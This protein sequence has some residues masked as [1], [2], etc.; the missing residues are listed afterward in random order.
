MSSKILSGGTNYNN[1]Y[2]C[3]VIVCMCQMLDSVFFFYVNTIHTSFKSKGLDNGQQTDFNCY[4]N[5]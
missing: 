1:T 5:L 2:F 4:A 3:I